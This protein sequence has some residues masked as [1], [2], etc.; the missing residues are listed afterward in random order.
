MDGFRISLS[1]PPV[2]P[3]KSSLH[4]FSP[5][6][7]EFNISFSFHL[8]DYFVCQCTPAATFSR[9]SMFS[10]PRSAIEEIPGFIFFLGGRRQPAKGILFIPQVRFWI[11]YLYETCQFRFLTYFHFLRNA[12]A[13]RVTQLPLPQP[14][15][16]S[17][18]CSGTALNS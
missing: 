18:Q 16:S 8:A 11:L 5:T 10:T 1:P 13:K 15:S 17:S 12:S 9:I 3:I 4:F 7:R 2:A 6:H 14:H